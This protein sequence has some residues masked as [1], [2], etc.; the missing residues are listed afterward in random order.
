MNILILGKGAREHAIINK[1][2]KSKDIKTIYTL[3]IGYLEKHS[4]LNNCDLYNL[5][6]DDSFTSILKICY[7]YNISLVVVGPEKYLVKGINDFLKSY[8]IECFGPNQYASRIEGS[9]VFSKNLMKSLNI[10][11]ADYYIFED[12][13]EAS[14][15]FLEN[16]YEEYVI[17]VSGLA[18]GKGVI[19]PKS[20]E[21]ALDTLKKI[22]IDNKFGEAGS[23]IVVEKRLHGVEV[24][25]MGFCN[26]NTIELMPQSKDY[27]RIYDDNLGPNTGGMGSHC[28]V[29]ILNNE[30]LIVLKKNMEKIVKKLNYKGVLYAGVIKTNNEVYILEFNCRFGDPEA[31]VLLS[32]LKNDLYKIMLECLDG[33]EIN[34]EWSDKYASN[35]VLS[36]KDYPLSKLSDKVEIFFNDELH[37][38]IKLY[39]AN[40]I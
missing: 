11:T 33:K 18:A 19:L 30:E 25:V 21:E 31:Q 27:K 14:K 2:S 13:L 34:I 3:S 6:R 40:V 23:Q 16:N 39:L 24:S 35:I 10:P 17:K 9:K 20:K 37:N 1:L 26:G 36:H 22:F 12:Y 7:D 5:Q 38:D 15:F 29:H 32:L 4:R 8:N 28:P